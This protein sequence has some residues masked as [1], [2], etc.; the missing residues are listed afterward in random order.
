MYIPNHFKEDDQDKLQQYIRDY[1]FG[2]L[3]IA[4]DEGVEAN[5]VP[6]HLSSGANGSLGNLQCH[7]ARSNPVW[8]R[9]QDGARV[10]AV[11]KGPDAYVSPSWYPT[12]A[13]TGRV[14]PT[15]N[16]LAVHAEGSAQ[17][18]QDS[19]W[20]K[21][22][23]H[24]LTEQHESQMAAPWSVDDAPGDFTDRLVQAIVG[25][26]IKIEALTGKLK[27]SQNQPEKNRIGVKAGLET[28]EGTQNRAM[29]QFIS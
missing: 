10:L 1:S 5:H 9:M 2:M 20:L 13:E 11:F 16:Y 23:L 3:I 17:I 14:V 19:S 12:K 24:Q 29:A 26:E 15:W 25:V 28:G 22:H 27:A 7:L 4:D 21:H 8:Q 6:F 18:I